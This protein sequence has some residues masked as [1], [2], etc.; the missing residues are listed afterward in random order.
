MILLFLVILVAPP[1]P[2]VPYLD[3]DYTFHY[4]YT[5]AVIEGEPMIGFTCITDSL[6]VDSLAAIYPAVVT[7]GEEIFEEMLDNP[8]EFCERFRR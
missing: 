8:E 7:L 4:N 5:G 1:P 6:D 3:T 2:I